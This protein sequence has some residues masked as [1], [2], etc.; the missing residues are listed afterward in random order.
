M[1]LDE[2][3]VAADDMHWV[4]TTKSS[5]SGKLGGS[6]WS[7]FN[8][9]DM[10]SKNFYGSDFH[11]ELGPP[12]VDESELLLGEQCDALITAITPRAFLGGD[13]GIRR[14][15]PNVRAAEQS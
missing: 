3:G 7:A 2:Y 15:F 10:H 5:D 13:P 6:G 12:N 4:E 8:G 9:I 1:L 14:L 11:I